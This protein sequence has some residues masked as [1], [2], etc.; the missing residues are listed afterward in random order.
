MVA[1]KFYEEYVK[2]A[3]IANVD[4]IVC[5]AGLP[6]DLPKF[7][8][9]TNVKIA[10]IV[11]SKK[12]ASLIIRQWEKKYNRYPDLI[13]IEGPLAGGHLGFN[14]N[15]LDTLIKEYD[16]QDYSASYDEE[17]KEI[18]EYIRE[19][20]KE[21]NIQIPVVAGGGV[22]S[23]DDMTHYMNLGLDGVQV[24]T[25]FVATYEC[26]ASTEY[27]QAYINARKDDVVIIKSPVGMP[28]RA[29]KN[30]FLEAI[31]KGTRILGKCRQCVKTCDISK[32]PYCI[33]KALIE[34]VKGNV[35]EGLIFCGAHVDRITRMESVKEIMDEF[36][37]CQ[38][39]FL[40]THSDFKKA[41]TVL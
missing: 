2:A 8:E 35:K 38:K 31:S 40:L 16:E 33:A 19:V 22:F 18:V 32:T 30:D 3:V 12:A 34:A 1:T 25:R 26:D 9:G 20:E 15:D 39:R 14:N 13:V 4:L 6:M 41:D 29:I 17:I 24:G 27:K 11:S 5:G 37:E 23:S 28:A 36:A 10:P 7:V 21:K